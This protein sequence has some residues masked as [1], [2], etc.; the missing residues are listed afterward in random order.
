MIQ[1][2]HSLIGTPYVYGGGHGGWGNG[3]GLDCSGFVSTV[4]HS[5]GYLNAPQTTEGFAAQPGIAAGHGHYVTIYDRTGCGANEHVII[6]LNGTL[7]RGGRRRYQ[8]RRAV[9][10]PVRA[11]RVLLGLLQHHPASSR[12]VRWVPGQQVVRW[13][14]ARSGDGGPGGNSAPHR[15]AGAD[16]RRPA[17]RSVSV[18]AR[19][20]RRASGWSTSP[21]T[22]W[23]WAVPAA[24][25]WRSPGIPGSR[26]ST[27]TWSGGDRV[28]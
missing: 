10:P 9:R 23:C 4:L 2:A 14:R 7:L 3:S 12:A 13:P 26:A 28:G 17:R 15:A 21:A 1:T 11:Q 22:G 25:T 8:R 5:A 20:R 27:P 18:P 24:A 19:R 16:P 6:D